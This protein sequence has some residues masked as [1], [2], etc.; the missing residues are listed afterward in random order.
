MRE[1]GVR[2]RERERGKEGC[3]DEE[4][5]EGEGEMEG[6]IETEEEEGKKRG[7]TFKKCVCVHHGEKEGQKV[8]EK[9]IITLLGMQEWQIRGKRSKVKVERLKVLFLETQ[10][11]LKR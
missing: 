4:E 9:K 2:Q 5:E 3:R 6:S 7:K 11:R 10:C 1:E 8:S